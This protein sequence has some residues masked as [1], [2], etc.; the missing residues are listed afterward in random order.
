M[1][2]KYFYIPHVIEFFFLFPFLSLSC[3]NYRPSLLKIYDKT[4]GR[5]NH[6]ASVI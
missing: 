5:Q 4:K 6:I 2:L 3:D 1:E